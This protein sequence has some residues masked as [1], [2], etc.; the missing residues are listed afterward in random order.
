MD[1]VNH[2]VSIVAFRGHRHCGLSQICN[3]Q[4]M[5]NNTEIHLKP[6]FSALPPQRI[7]YIVEDAL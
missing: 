7:F 6:F 3:F 5:F 2:S 4:T 1:V